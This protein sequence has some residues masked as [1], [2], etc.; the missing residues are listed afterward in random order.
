MQ[1]IT[2]DVCKK[3][4]DNAITGRTFFYFG[5]NNVCEPCRD[6]LEFQIKNTVRTKDPFNYELY[7]KLILDSLGKS[8][9]K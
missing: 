6:N 5:Q 3:K 9:K 2:C 8:V 1:T 7:N 4:V